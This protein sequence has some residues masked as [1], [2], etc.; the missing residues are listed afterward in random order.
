MKE[1][2]IPISIWL[3]RNAI[4]P[5]MA[6]SILFVVAMS[7]MVYVIVMTKQNEYQESAQR[8]L[9]IAEL[10]TLQKNRPFVESLVELG[11][12]DIG[13]SSM[14][15][16]TNSKPLFL[17]P[18]N[19]QHCQLTPKFW[20]TT[21]VHILPGTENSSIQAIIPRFP[22]WEIGLWGCLVAIFFIIT[23]SI[24]F[25]R[26]GLKL[27]NQ[28]IVPILGGVKNEE[29]IGQLI[30][31]TKIREL[32]DIFGAYQRKVREIREL[33]ALN[34][35]YAEDAAIAK[36]TQ[37]LAHDLKNPLSLFEFAIDADSPEDF[38][39]SKKDLVRALER[40]HSIIGN[41]SQKSKGIVIRREASVLNIESIVSQ[42][43]LTH[44]KKGI[45]VSIDG[46]TNL[47]GHFDK[48][49]IERCLINL[50][51]N[52][53][54]AG[55]NTVSL[56]LLPSG[57]DL[58]IEVSDNGPGV[59]Q[60]VLPRLFSRGATFGKEA[61]E[62]IGLFNVRSI[63]EAHGGEVSYHRENSESIFKLALLGILNDGKKS[64]KPTNTDINVV[65]NIQEQAPFIQGKSLSQP[66]VLIYLSDK[67]R[68]AQLRA[69]LQN[70]TVDICVDPATSSNPIL[71]YTDN[72][73]EISR[74]VNKGVKL[75]L[76]SSSS[77]I[78]SASRQIQLMV[79]SINHSATEGQS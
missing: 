29:L 17:Y 64:R 59:S 69:A 49:A 32:S 38:A 37:A 31:D 60:E 34:A 21:L 4:R 23:S 18:E 61:G 6:T 70:L 22:G 67:G 28:V 76:D 65:P 77:S 53:I 42:F 1:K 62:G 24:I 68:S 54:E 2:A 30:A 78:E 48:T 66:Q 13:L 50:V 71:I 25:R 36:T 15:I 12:K 16:C 44:G 72:I 10:A 56:V 9:K 73:A 47:E 58:V 33:G 55:A 79:K 39:K 19:G 40:I 8:L 7:F 11:K 75:C 43:N 26:I 35:K 41:I 52:A 45:N 74:L 51:V 46:Q 20:Q 5:L 3:S 27:R 14:S 57:Q 63:I